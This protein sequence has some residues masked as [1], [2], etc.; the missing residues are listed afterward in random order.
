[1]QEEALAEQEHRAGRTTVS[2]LLQA[3]AAGDESAWAELVR[4]QSGVVW[5]VIR[6]Y[7]IP[8]AAVNDVYQTVWLRLIENVHKIRDPQ[9]LRGWLATTT[10]RECLDA[11][12]RAD[13]LLCD[14]DLAD[15]PDRAPSTEELCLLGIRNRV[16]SQAIERLPERDR[17]L[18]RILMAD[19]KPGYRDVSTAL[20]MPLGSI[21]PTRARALARLRS[22]FAKLGFTEYAQIA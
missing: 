2:Q 19:P 9:C 14:T 22:E 5:F 16:V 6:A 4:T 3:A 15:R 18:L 21:G 20:G 13:R 1:V 10:R 11:I 7:R 17:R 8:Q 12:R